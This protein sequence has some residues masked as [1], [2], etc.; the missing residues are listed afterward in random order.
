MRSVL[1]AILATA[2]VATSSP[3]SATHTPNPASD[4]EPTNTHQDCRPAPSPP[5]APAAAKAKRYADPLASL[6][7]TSPTCRAGV[8]AAAR[9]NCELSGSVAH[10]HPLSSYGF[11]VQI[12]FSLTDMNDSFLGA[13]Q[14][15]AAMLWMA[16]VFLV[17]GVL[18]LLEWAFSIDLLGTAMGDVRQTLLTLH[19]RVIGEPWF[20]AAIAVTALWGIWRGLV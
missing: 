7:A 19:H 11:D 9:R 1:V 4:C 18:L 8:D 16:L 14:S 13:L 17:K 12:G 6:G 2:F 3:A 5:P 10:E 15:L 20:L